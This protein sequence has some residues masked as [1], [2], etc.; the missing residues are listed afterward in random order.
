[1]ASII[2]TDTLQEK[3]AEFNFKTFN[4]LTF[5]KNITFVFYAY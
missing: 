5:C 2:S 3:C 1:M 4:Y